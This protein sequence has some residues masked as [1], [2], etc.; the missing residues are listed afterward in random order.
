MKSKNPRPISLRKNGFFEA[1]PKWKA[2]NLCTKAQSTT[3]KMSTPQCVG[4]TRNG[5]RC[6]RGGEPRRMNRCTQ[7]WDIICSN[8]ARKT[9]LFEYEMVVKACKRNYTSF[10]SKQLDAFKRDVVMPIVN[11]LSENDIEMVNM[12]DFIPQVRKIFRD[13]QIPSNVVKVTEI[14]DAKARSRDKFLMEL[15]RHAPSRTVAPE[16]RVS[17]PIPRYP[18]ESMNLKS[19]FTRTPTATSIETETVAAP[20]SVS[21]GF[22]I[23]VH[24]PKPPYFPETPSEMNRLRNH[25]DIHDS[26]VERKIG[27]IVR[28]LLKLEVNDELSWNIVSVSRTPG[29]IISKCNLPIK[30]AN[31]LMNRYTSEDSMFATG[32]GT[33]GRV[34]D[35]VWTIICDQPN[36]SQKEMQIELRDALIRSHDM[37]LQGSL[38]LLCNVV[39]NQVESLIDR[40]SPTH[41]MTSALDGLHRIR[42]PTTRQTR[43]SELMDEIGMPREARN[44]WLRVVRDGSTVNSL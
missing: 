23:N 4:I 28:N 44:L 33:Y 15:M 21:T 32:P 37:C 24:E 16:P 39:R 17:F 10:P 11:G 42:D 8:K 31:D 40:N 36:T 14:D 6:T 2:V 26:I 22:E 18:I 3:S 5:M 34:V 19:A 30:I 29:K 35:A 27:S 12:T 41:R 20:L 43:A 9:A 7:H 1:G 13:N 38:G 25:T